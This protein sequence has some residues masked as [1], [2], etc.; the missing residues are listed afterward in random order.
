MLTINESVIADAPDWHLSDPNGDARPEN[1]NPRS[2]EKM[3]I[4]QTTKVHRLSSTKRSP[5]DAFVYV[6]RIPVLPEADET[7]ED[8]AGRI[9][10]RLANQEGRVQLKLPPGMNRQAYQGFKIALES[11]RERHAG[12]CFACHHLPGLQHS[13]SK[14]PIPSL[15]NHTI[16]KVQLR[17]VLANEAHRGIKLDTTDINRLHALVQIFTDVP[18]SEF[19]NLILNTTVL[20]TFGDP[21]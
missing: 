18:D 3:N 8:L 19:R 2:G 9:L 17:A 4:E 12:R 1:R 10:G 13:T 21:E 15:R 6:N 16:S 11:G 14:P 5:F 20:D 7:H